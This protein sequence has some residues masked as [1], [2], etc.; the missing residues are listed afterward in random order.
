MIA[1]CSV[2]GGRERDLGEC[3][4]GLKGGF[5]S[6]VMIVKEKSE[7]HVACD[8]HTPVHMGPRLHDYGQFMVL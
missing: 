3:A 2:R 7:S 5:V 4:G 1:R 6:D 8:P